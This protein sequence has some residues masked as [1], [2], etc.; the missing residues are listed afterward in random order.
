MEEKAM[1]KGKG[2]ANPSGFFPMSLICTKPETNFRFSGIWSEVYLVAYLPCDGYLEYL[3]EDAVLACQARTVCEL[4][5]E[6]GF[7]IDRFCIRCKRG[8]IDPD[9]CPAF[10]V[11]R[12]LT[13]CR[14]LDGRAFDRHAVT[15]EIEKDSG[16]RDSDVTYICNGDGRT[17]PIRSK[18]K[19]RRAAWFAQLEAACENCGRRGN[20]RGER[21]DDGDGAVEVKH[22]GIIAFFKRIFGGRK[23]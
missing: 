23:A 19:D 5:Y 13:E 4:K 20:D 9:C 22:G 16:N 11:V 6:A 21:G 7:D 15:V 3:A 8:V 1:Q 18:Y 14:M 10:E 12:R 2:K 17:G